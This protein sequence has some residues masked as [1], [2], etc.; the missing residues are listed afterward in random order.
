MRL[1]CR[2]RQLPLSS[3]TENT[4]LPFIL[5]RRCSCLAASKKYSSSWFLQAP[6]T[7]CLWM[8]TNSSLKKSEAA[9]EKAPRS[10]LLY[11]QVM[12][13]KTLCCSE[14]VEDVCCKSLL[15][16]LS[17][18]PPRGKSTEKSFFGGVTVWQRQHLAMQRFLNRASRLTSFSWSKSVFYI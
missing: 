9:Q 18:T 2:S 4:L 11:K 12:V 8:N 15:V 14:T 16:L 1:S 17:L 5:L 7:S 3:P 13:R 6:I 10:V